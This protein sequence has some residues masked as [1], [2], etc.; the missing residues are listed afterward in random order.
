VLS[1]NTDETR[2]EALEFKKHFKTGFATLVNGGSVARTYGVTGIPTNV[3]I[4]KD[5]KIARVIEGF[6][7][8]TLDAAVKSV[9]AK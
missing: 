4:R 1:V 7:A 3:V 5:G 9:A 8:Q 2:A 6:D